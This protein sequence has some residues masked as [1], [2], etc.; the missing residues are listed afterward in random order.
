[1]YRALRRCTLQYLSSCR[2]WTSGDLALAGVK[3]GLKPRRR[4]TGPVPL[5]VCAAWR[6]TPWLGTECGGFSVC[7][8]WRR[9]EMADAADLER[10]MHSRAPTPRALQQ[11]AQGWR[12]GGPL[13]LGSLPEGARNLQGLHLCRIDDARF[14]FDVGRH[15]ESWASGKTC[16][17]PKRER[18]AAAAWEMGMH[19]ARRNSVSRVGAVT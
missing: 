11:P 19:Y 12:D 10:V 13:T 14:D 18:N 16:D 4:E 3:H 9:G 1:V 7:R 17:D 15:G 5:L 6:F 8:A 2:V